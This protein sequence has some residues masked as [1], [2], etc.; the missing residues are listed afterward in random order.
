MAKPPPYRRLDAAH[1]VASLTKLDARIRDRFPDAG[2]A[3]VCQDL[4][5][6]T[7]ANTDRAA[8]I[9]RRDWWL[10]LVALVLLAATVAGLGTLARTLVANKIVDLSN[11]KP[12]N[13]YTLIQ[14]MDA[15]IHIFFVIGGLLFFLVSM[16]DR[17]KRRRAIRALNELRSIIHVVDMHQ[18][19]K[20]PASSFAG[21]A[22]TPNSPK[23]TLTPFELGRYLDYC[24]EMLALIAKVAVL[25]AQALPDPVI[26]DAVSD[27]ERLTS[28]LSQKIWSKISLIHTLTGGFDPAAAPTTSHPD[29]VDQ[30]L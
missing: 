30:D 9:A 14:A 24:S 3:R 25:Y 16:E 13:V 22:P 10:W 8:A 19:T 6:I 7:R 27:I 21:G 17:L 29:P 5:T 15:F 18:L 4:I 28:N 1:L 2:L 11:P 20:E 12:E 26:V 23:R